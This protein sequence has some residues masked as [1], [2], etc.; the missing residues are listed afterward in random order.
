MKITRQHIACAIVGSLS[1]VALGFG[2]GF[3]PPEN[4]PTVEWHDVILLERDS[5]TFD[6]QMRHLGLDIW[7]ELQRHR[8]GDIYVAVQLLNGSVQTA[9][10]PVRRGGDQVDGRRGREGGSAPSGRLAVQEVSGR[11]ARSQRGN[12]DLAAVH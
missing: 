12:H 2:Y 3:S 4:R 9:A 11:P 7:P 6:N 5:E 8:S 10:L 1:T